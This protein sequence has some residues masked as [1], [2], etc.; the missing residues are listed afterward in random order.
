MTIHFEI[1]GHPT[2][3]KR[4]RIGRRGPFARMF[5]PKENRDAKDTVAVFAH[6]AMKGEPPME[7]PLE[8][9]VTF[10]FVR[11]KSKIRKRPP[12]P[13]PYPSGKPDVDNLIKLLA[14]GCNG[15]VYRD[16]AQIVMLTADKV[17]AQDNR[18]R[19]VVR[20]EDAA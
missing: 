10:Y 12:D 14:D 1:P 5:D 4:A 15:I 20:I 13:F 11:P 19:T 16:D 17:W 8:L 6:K 9:N 18:P 7:G 3:L 2:A